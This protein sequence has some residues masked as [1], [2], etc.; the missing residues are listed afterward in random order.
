LEYAL[1]AAQASKVESFNERMV[2]SSAEDDILQ[3]VVFD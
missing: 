3:V 1:M 2:F